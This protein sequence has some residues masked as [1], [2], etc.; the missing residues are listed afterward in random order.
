MKEIAYAWR[1]LRRA[2]GPTG[3]SVVTIGI[4]IAVS[5]VLFAL[6]DG[7]VLRPL[8]YPTADRLVTIVDTNPALG[9]DRTGA[10]SGNIDDWRRL[11]RSFE[12]IA[13]YYTIGRTLS[14]E[15]S[16]VV[17]T[18]Q[19]STDFFP[20]TRVTPR[21]GRTFTE[22]E[23]LAAQFNTAAAPI[24]SNPVVI[25]GHDLWRQRFGG[26][27]DIVG[28]SVML[29]RQPFQIVGVM[30]AG[31]GLPQADV[32]LWIPWDLSGER[33]RD[34]H[35]L[36]AV[37]RVRPGVSIGQAQNELNS[38][39]NELGRRYPDT[40]AG[41]GVRLIPLAAEVVGDSAR[42]LWMLFGAVGL[43][44][45]VACANV[46]LLS[47]MRGL[48][49]SVENA[50]RLALGS[51]PGRLLRQSWVESLLLALLGGALGVGLA[52][53]GLQLLPRL[54]P[55]LPRLDD[56]ALDVRVLW[57]AVAVTTL[58]A[59]L[60]GLL[61]AW[62]G[63]QTEPARALGAGTLRSTAT[64]RQHLVRDGLVVGQVALALMLL[65]GSGLLVRSFLALRAAD[66]GFDPSGVLVAPI[67][68]DTQAYGS[69]EQARAYY[70]AL[71]DQLEALPGVT[72]VG[73]ATT[74][75]TSP[76]GP[77]FDRPVWPEGAPDDRDRVQ[78]AVRM[79]TPGYFDA[80]RLPIA[81]GRAFDTRDHPDAPPVVMVSETLARRLWP[82]QS[83]VGQSLVVDY[84][85]VGTYPYEVVGVVGDVRFRG[86]RSEPRAEIYLPHAQR[87]YLI[88]HV[89]VRSA[90]DPRTLIPAVR[91]VLKEI[92]PQKPAFG[93]TPLED[94]VGATMLRDR[95]AML[96]LLAFASA[97][98][99]LAMLGV[100]GVLSARVRERRQEIGVRM[101][102]GANQARLMGWVAAGGLRLLGYGAALGLAATWPLTGLLSG[103]LFGVQPTDPLTAVSVVALLFVVGVGATLVP[104]W[105]ATRV[106]PV[107]V[108]RRG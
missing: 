5:T 106:D 46:A 74:L 17:L 72:A 78:A 108:L 54:V 50:V 99:F 68:L 90:G 83:A 18:A 44:L 14:A 81:G 59:C 36:G 29:E 23:T 97:A 24:G 53:G 98:V 45:L 26:D 3:L 7:V 4:G 91:A 71:F 80:L 38:V 10:A 19:V 96:A 70:A 102:L 62:R 61:P 103:F 94:L 69:G 73:G 79:V 47:V 40:N 77:D 9:V 52:A 6:I 107:A 21:L 41:W 66:P 95:Q 12:G 87:S 28:S 65:C 13:G 20:L 42:V 76:L 89:A 84:S 58:V 30:P 104:S 1:V 93:L 88:M 16:D 60:S 27:P 57:F 25:I 31:F 33:P 75:P 51:T 8:P 67:F 35:Y 34:Q 15:T 32:Q 92:D 101:A 63:A 55:D 64:A 49:R 100:Y 86:P 2:P 48:D 85:T 43:V 82:E 56:V 39:A 105:R 11:S 37:A 22:A